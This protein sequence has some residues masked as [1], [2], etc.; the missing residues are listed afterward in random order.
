MW[1][2]FLSRVEKVG[3]DPADSEEIRI[4]KRMLVAITGLVMVFGAVWGAAYWL[5]G[6]P[7]AGAIPGG[8]SLL[9]FINL[10]VFS[11]TRQYQLF[12]ALQL[13][14]FLALPFF[15]QVALGGFVGS[16]A[17]ILWALTAPL[18]ALVMQGR[19]ESVPWMIGFGALLLVSLL[20][21]P[22]MVINNNLSPTVV[23]VFFLLNL[24]AVSF[25]VFIVLN[26]FVGQRDRIQGQLE[27]EQ[28]KSEN[29]L[30]NVLPQRVADD[31]KEKGETKA[32]AHESVTVLFADSVGFT[33]FADSVSPDEMLG[34]LSEVFTGFDEIVNRHGVEKIRTIGDAYMAAS[35]VPVGRQDHADA[36]AKVALEMIAQVEGIDLDFRIGINSGSVVAGVIGTTKFQYD[37][38]GDAVNTASRMESSGEQG[39]I[40]IGESTYELIKERFICEP[41]GTVNIKG[42]GELATWWLIGERD[43]EDRS[44]TDFPDVGLDEAGVLDEV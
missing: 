13:L 19:R 29:L 31:L 38:W 3:A 18:G 27:V 40:Q 26:Y 4:Q 37:I 28:E 9:T 14:F 44:A 32:E 25:V 34:V 43:S 23:G 20:V 6:E 1:E 39:R 12:R 41:R 11:K 42:K 16:S 36:M 5:L 17:V 33:V 24:L 21:Q 8:Y 22:E 2:W 15:L 35:G 30:L 7:L 10:V